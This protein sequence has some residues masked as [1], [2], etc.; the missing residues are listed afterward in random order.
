MNAKAYGKSV[1]LSELPATIEV[2]AGIIANRCYS[3][4]NF[5]DCLKIDAKKT[6]KEEAKVFYHQNLDKSSEKKQILDTIEQGKDF[7]IN[8]I[9]CSNTNK[10]WYIPLPPKGRKA[11]TEAELEKI[12][13]GEFVLIGFLSV[14]TPGTL[15]S[16]VAAGGMAAVA[17]MGIGLNVGGATALTYAGIVGASIAG[18]AT[19]AAIATSAALTQIKV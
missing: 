18:V 1:K 13:E 5:R 19:V 12:V 15:V 10:K 11:V 17:A 7:N 14:V 4:T 3:D 9:I 16:T 2:Q 6:F 8:I